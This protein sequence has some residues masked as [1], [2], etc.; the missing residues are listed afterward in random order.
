MASRIIRGAKGRFLKHPTIPKGAISGD[1]Q[2]AINAFVTF[3]VNIS[4]Y[5]R[6]VVG[7]ETE[8]VEGGERTFHQGFIFR[9]KITVE[10]AKREFKKGGHMYKAIVDALPPNVEFIEIEKIK[11]NEDGLKGRIEGLQAKSMKGYPSGFKYL[12]PKGK[13]SVIR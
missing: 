2:R 1:M 4:A 6:K 5:D 13:H 12:K 10:D 7:G 9:T 3:K 8:H 11:F